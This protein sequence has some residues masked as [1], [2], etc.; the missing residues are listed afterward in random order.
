MVVFCGGL[1][2]NGT[3]MAFI[4]SNVAAKKPAMNWLR[5][6]SLGLNN[7]PSRKFSV[8]NSIMGI[9]SYL[10]INLTEFRY[11]V[12][13]RHGTI[14]IHVLVSHLKNNNKEVLL[15]VLLQQVSVLKCY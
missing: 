1:L 13:N 9:I 5:L 11:S 4:A 15:W 14:N 12:L 6:Y 7:C 8:N 10:P 3:E 2:C